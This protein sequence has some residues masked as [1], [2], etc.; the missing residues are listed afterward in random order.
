[1]REPIISQVSWF[2]PR[3][4][5][6]LLVIAVAVFAGVLL[7][8]RVM[9]G[10]DESVYAGE[11]RMLAHGRLSPMAGDPLPS[12][13]SVQDYE[14]PRYPPGWPLI[15]T[16]GA[17]WSFRAMFLITLVVHA[18]GG[19]A[20]AR[21]AVRRGIPS[22][23]VAVWLFHPLFWHFS[24][25][26][27]SDLCAAALLL[28]AMDAWEN[29]SIK[30][31]AA[32]IAYSFLVRFA[33]AIQTAGFLLAVTTDV[34]R[35]WR[36]LAI[37]AIGGVIGVIGLLLAN[38]IKYGHPF[39]S[40]YASTNMGL[41]NT[42]M[43]WRNLAVY[44][45]GLVLIPPFPIICLLLRP[46]SCDRWALA[47]IPIVVFF[48]FYGYRELAT[49]IVENLLIGQRL[50][51]SAHAVLLV[52]TMPVWSRFPGVRSAPLLIAIGLMSLATD[53][54][55]IGQTRD[56]YEPAAKVLAACEPDRVAFNLYAAPVALSTN[57]SCYE[58]IGRE[59]PASP[60][61]MAVVTFRFRNTQY[62]V[63]IGFH[64]PPWLKRATK[65]CRQLGDFFVLDLNGRCPSL[66]NACDSQF[67]PH[68]PATHP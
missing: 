3:L 26:I 24:R 41:L 52:S 37:I 53:Y 13:H 18:L 47:A 49:N 58:L 57:A 40:S 9:A 39:H 1:M 54:F 25:T 10:S 60:P 67:L 23:L 15:L 2:D 38:V 65:H 14:G 28:I 48:L 51:L 27:L 68:H 7:L 12:T 32:A 4:R 30:T 45:L 66:G 11:A 22:L 59:E 34:R 63:P 8:P 6:A 61:D 29:R 50:I 55:L 36:P 64:V 35:R 5:P 33:S 20:F 16:L 44:G 19:A 56:Y 46:R 62:N 31:S 21:M 17:L 42:S 43:F